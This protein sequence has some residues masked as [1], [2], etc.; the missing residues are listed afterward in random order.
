MQR[1]RSILANEIKKLNMNN[2]NFSFSRY[3]VICQMKAEF[4]FD[5]NCGFALTFK[6]SKKN[7]ELYLDV[8]YGYLLTFYLLLNNIT[9]LFGE[10]ID[11]YGRAPYCKVP[12]K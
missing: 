6:L 10:A 7:M 11:N 12:S 4:H 5:Q 2:S 8:I 1:V 3:I 9:E